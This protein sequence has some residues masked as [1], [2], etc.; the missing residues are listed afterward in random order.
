MTE[1]FNLYTY[2]DYDKN[3]MLKKG[4]PT[5]MSV[6]DCD[7]NDLN[8][9]FKKQQEPINDKHGK[10][11]L[12]SSVMAN[13]K[14]DPNFHIDVNSCNKPSYINSDP[15]LYNAMAAQWLH[16]DKPPLLS[17]PKL[18]TINTDKSLNFYGKHYK[19]YSDV[20][21]GQIVYY[22]NRDTEDAFFEPLYVTKAEAVGTLYQDPMGAIKPQ[23]DR[24][25]KNYNPILEKDI[26][27]PSS[28]M[29]DSLFH[30]EDLLS[31]QMRKMN[32][33]RYAPRYS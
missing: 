3:P 22:I 32:K 26:E 8:N 24:I 31:L 10:Y 7:F 25:G 12:N 27:G 9:V 11:I 15:R 13:D 21:A 29:K 5:N 23:W 16:L 30:R 4:N 6:M 19:S 14:F 1:N 2:S 20:N 28:F 17:T 33:Q 18:N